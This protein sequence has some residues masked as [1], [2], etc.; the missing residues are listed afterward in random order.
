MCSKVVKFN[1]NDKDDEDDEDDKCKWT[2]KDKKA[3]QDRMRL[4]LPQPDGQLRWAA[5]QQRAPGTVAA[6][7]DLRK[8]VEDVGG[9]P[10]NFRSKLTM[11]RYVIAREAPRGVKREK[12]DGEVFSGRTLVYRGQPASQ[13][14]WG[15]GQLGYGTL[16]MAATTQGA[17]ENRDG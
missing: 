1:K 5:F 7:S 10:A 12:D 15:V 17:M 6:S 3:L 16:T 8:M 9:N 11:A 2:D 13:K 14:F 4:Y